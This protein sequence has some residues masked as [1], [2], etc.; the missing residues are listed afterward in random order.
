MKNPLTG[1]MD[2]T[3]IP[4]EEDILSPMEHIYHH[5]LNITE[6]SPIWIVLYDSGVHNFVDFMVMDKEDFEECEGV[7]PHDTDRSQDRTIKM[8]RVQIKK[9]LAIQNWY[10]SQDSEDVRVIY[11][12][13][14]DILQEFIL[15][16]QGASPNR[17][18]RSPGIP[19][20]IPATP[21]ASTPHSRMSHSSATSSAQLFQQSI[22][23]SVSD[24]TTKLKDDKYWFNYNQAL[25]AQAKTHGLSNV[26]DP[27]YVPETIDDQELFE[28]QNS[29][30]FNVFQNTLHTMKSKKQIRL[31]A[32]KSD[33][34]AV[35][36]GLLKDY[37]S[38][39]VADIA[40]EK[41]EEEIQ[42]M[43]LDKN[44]NKPYC[45]FLDSWEH[46][47][48]DLEKMQKHEVS[49]DKKRK[50]LTAAIRQNSELYSAI[51]NTRTIEHILKGMNLGTA[52]PIDALNWEQFY[53][54]IRS[55]ATTSD[56]KRAQQSK[57]RQVN[58]Q[59]RDKR[60]KNRQS[61]QDRQSNDRNRRHSN[62]SKQFEYKKVPRDKWKKMTADQKAAHINAERK[63]RFGENYTPWSPPSREVKKTE[64]EV[65]KTE[66]SNE[67]KNAP[68]AA[69]QMFSSSNTMAPG[70]E[71]SVNGMTFVV[72]NANVTYKF[73]NFNV[74]SHKGGS[75]ID[76]GASGGLSG[77][78]V[79]VLEQHPTNKADVSG[80]GD[81]LIE[82]VPICTVA[83]VIQTT[84]GPIVGIFH[85]YAHYG[86][87]T[88]IH[89]VNQLGA[90]GL[91]VNEKPKS[92]P[93]GKQRIVTPEG[94]VIP[95]AIRRGLAYM[96]MYPPS[97]EELEKYP[98]VTFTSDAE[99]DPS[100]L[101][102]EVDEKEF[103]EGLSDSFDSQGDETREVNNKIVT[104][105]EPD[106]EKL[107]PNFG[108]LPEKRIK[109]TLKAT[110]QW[111]KADARMYFRQHL[112][113]RFPAANVNRLNETVATDTFFSDTEA[114]D[115]GITGHGGAT[116]V[117]L[118]TGKESHLTEAFPMSSQTQ[119][120]QT[121]MD[122][123]RK[124][125][126]PN[127]LLS[128]GAKAE[129]GKK[130]VDILRHYHIRD[131]QSEPYYQNQ[132]PAE[133]R[134]QDVKHI[135]NSIMDRTGTPAKFWLLCTLFV[136]YLLNCCASESLGNITPIERATGQRPDI[137][138]LLT[139]HWWEP[140]YF[141]SYD[142]KFPSKG[143]ERIG[144][145][146]GVAENT[147]DALTYLILDSVTEKVV[148]RSVVRT[149]TNLKDPNYRPVNVPTAEGEE[150]HES[151]SSFVRSVKDVLPPHVDPADVKLP[152]FSPHELLGM[153]FVHTDANGNQQKA[154]V[155]K[156]INDADAQNHQNLKFLLKL[157]DGE[158]E[159]VIGYTELVDS[160][161]QQADE[162]VQMHVYK[163]IIGHEGPLRPG[164]KNYMGS[165]YNLKVEWMDGSTTFEPLS[166]MAKD[167]PISCARYGMNNDL[168]NKPGW[169]S[170]KRV[171]KRYHKVHK[172]EIN[173]AKRGKPNR[174]KKKEKKF[175][176]GVQVPDN[177]EEAERLD[178]QNGDTKWKDSNRLELDQLD[179][180]NVF[181]DLG[182]GAEP[183][184]GYKKI[185]LR[186]IYDVKHNL[187]HKAQYVAGGHLTDPCKDSAYSGVISLRTLRLALLV[188]ELNGLKVMVGD[189]GN[190][191]LEAYTKEKVYIIAGPE[192]GDRAGHTLIIDKAL[193]GLRTSGARFHEKLADTLHDMGFTP[194]KSDPDLWMRDAGDVY[195]YVCVYVDD[196]MAIMKNPQEFFDTLTEKY[197]YK[198]KGVGDPSYHLGG[199]FYRDPDGT[200]AWGA[201]S[202]IKRLCQNYSLMFGEEPKNASS[203]LVANDS[204]ELDTSPE[205]NDD[206]IKKYQSL[207]GALQWCVTLGRFDIACAVMTLSRFRANPREGHLERAKR[208]CGYLRKMSDGAIRFRTGIPFHEKKHQPKEHDWMYT[209]YGDVKEEVA[210]DAPP[211]KGK[212]VRTTTFVD[213]NLYHCKVTGRAATGILHI[214][215]Q[216]PV[217]WYS[218]RQNTVET[219]TYGSEFVAARIATEQIMDLRI[220]L[221]DMGVPVLG[222]SWMFG[223]N[224]SVITSSTLPHSSLNK[225]HNALAYHRVRAAVAAKIMH[226]CHVLGK[227]NIADVMTKFLA[228]ANFWPLIKPVLFCRGET[229]P[230]EKRKVGE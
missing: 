167:D 36:R 58:N 51:T 35:Y 152:S 49:D 126:A 87:G 190:A 37:A 199:D 16:G 178:K 183:P 27:N 189:I 41:I 197:K 13:D 71:F 106:A 53:E 135:T 163:D 66:V 221:R 62:D 203:P 102:C 165:S 220:V 31:H 68:T 219:A 205:L 168:L 217:D 192:F 91:D 125:G 158:M 86:K 166:M 76:G 97:D 34:Q 96:D 117:Q 74:K 56:A 204:P 60:N 42:G 64:V 57:H 3:F 180:Y 196:L 67:D 139:Y 6:S 175:K 115:D 14:E 78:D 213:A 93:G 47:I 186:C 141:H 72:K 94:F 227:E 101:D 162:E 212:G 124:R 181:R 26:L 63:R 121:F 151:T 24:Y 10:R 88:S 164:H 23:K 153:S 129:L 207:I 148:K 110:T 176:F 19:A 228:Y 112:K 82:D 150:E 120:P 128:D 21:A 144:R 73:N 89:S 113:T 208:I 12:L 70:T 4:R 114:H 122:F 75:L 226:F 229:I 200:L 142:N 65:K 201:K 177:F 61:Q 138:A 85:Q 92:I 79:R 136:V 211:P 194:C 146:V 119:F 202:Y 20:G 161:E 99:W 185:T 90:F 157:G 105:K 52:A 143:N 32:E 215:N 48:L 30:M 104:P 33:G 100:S 224:Q 182:K 107:R 132:N 95:L 134:I 43:R 137:S 84:S 156:K 198:L 116:M 55:Q 111:F 195:E 230:K 223:D 140:V 147:G 80:I 38:G 9:L 109:A 193:Y 83:G 154:T 17:H 187:R 18:S 214:V 69:E 171:A 7:I 133:R 184:P 29:F 77:S 98:Q 46:K 222:P 45:S 210:E 15:G 159:E 145:W 206:D 25:R 218:K 169:K 59:E 118:Y 174:K 127:A 173:Q 81:A 2:T 22:K 108:W 131:E 123:I 5:V 28:A 50:W 155:V 54:V 149:A 39:V 225:R 40:I 11:Q 209:V 172:I 179:E 191:Y 103:V 8:N 170:L 1:K 130:V 44:W 216:T 188:G 160:I